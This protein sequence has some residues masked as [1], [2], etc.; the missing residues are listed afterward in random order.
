M[1][2]YISGMRSLEGPGN[3]IYGGGTDWPGRRVRDVKEEISLLD[4]GNTALLTL[5]R[6]LR[7]SYTKDVKFEVQEDVFPAQ[8]VTMKVAQGSSGDTSVDMLTAA[9]AALVRVGDLWMNGDSG[10]VIYIRAKSSTTLSIIRGIGGTTVTD[11]ASDSD[12]MFYIGNAQQTGSQARPKLTTVVEMPYNYAQSF[13]EGWEIDRTADTT[14]LYGRPDRARLRKKHGQ[15]HNKDIER[16]LWL[17]VRDLRTMSDGTAAHMSKGLVAD[18][19]NG[20]ITSNWST[21]NSSGPYTED[22]FVADLITGFR[23]GSD[24]K[25]LFGAPMV[26]SVISSWG[27]AQLRTLPRDKT[28]GINITRYISPHGELNLINNK[29]FLD[30]SGAGTV[31]GA[32]IDFTKLAVIVDLMKLRYRYKRDTKLYEG[33]QE[34]D[35]DAVEDEYLTE[36][37]LECN[38]EKCHMG[39]QGFDI[40]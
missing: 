38:L 15:I 20:W 12:N 34:N 4:S 6:R 14:S 24:T 36:V 10:E 22:E 33:I 7:R 19:S 26:M 11:I 25:F 40:A 2:D 16:M 39:I 1:V 8:T 13:K 30:L 31:W 35:K 37:G 23:Y 29:L 28:Y 21:T 32:G 3:T 18:G 5:I 27:R 9:D 17:G